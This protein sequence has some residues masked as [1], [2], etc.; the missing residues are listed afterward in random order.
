MKGAATFVLAPAPARIRMRVM[1]GIKPRVR[2]TASSIASLQRQKIGLM[3]VNG[4][5]G[6][7][8][9]ASGTGK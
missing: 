2:T 3:I 6:S 1:G 5:M 7:A 9:W 8:A 4:K